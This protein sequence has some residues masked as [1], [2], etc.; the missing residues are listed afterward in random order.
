MYVLVIK[1]TIDILELIDGYTMNLLLYVFVVKYSVKLLI[2]VSFVRTLC[3]E[4]R[5]QW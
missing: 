1:L 2:V 5:A 4:L 3:V